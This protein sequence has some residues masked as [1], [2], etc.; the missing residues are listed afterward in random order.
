MFSALAA[1]VTVAP[2][3]SARAIRRGESLDAALPSRACAVRWV[4]LEI[5]GAA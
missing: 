3:A 1:S 5:V 2:D 4:S